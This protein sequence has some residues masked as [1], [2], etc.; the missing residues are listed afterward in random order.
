MEENE[1]EKEEYYESHPELQ[2]MADVVKTNSDFKKATS[3]KVKENSKDGIYKEKRLLIGSG[4][5]IIY[6]SLK[7]NILL[8]YRNILT[9]DR[10]MARDL[11]SDHNSTVD[12]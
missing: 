4:N 9:F 11:Q 3:N 2:T 8:D 10:N 7:C 12:I 6:L 1:H 5:N